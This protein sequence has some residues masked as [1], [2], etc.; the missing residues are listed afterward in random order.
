MDDDAPGDPGPGDPLVSDPLEDGSAEHPFDAIQEGID[1]SG[2]GDTVLVL[3]G[4]YTGFGNKNLDFGGRL[5]IVRSE[6]DPDSCIIN[7]QGNGRGFY[8]HSG[9]TAAAV[10]GGFTI[11]NG[12][13]DFN[14]G[15]V[16]MNDCSPTLINCTISASTAGSRGGGVHCAGDSSP[17]L[18]NCTITANTADS[19][20]GGVHCGGDSS[21]TLI[22]CTIAA[23]TSGDNGGGLY[24]F[25]TS[26][27][28]LANCILWGDTPDEVYC[29]SSCNPVVTYCDVQNGFGQTWFGAGCID[30]DPMFVDTDGPD[31]DPSTWED[32]DYRINL[33][34]PCTD[35]A[36]NTAVPPDTIDLDGDGDLDERIP[37]DGDGN[38]RF[39]DDPGTDDTGVPDPPAYPEVVDMGAYE[40]QEHDCNGNGVPDELD[41]SEGTSEDCT[42]NGIP[43]ECEPDCNENGVADSCDTIDGTSEDCNSNEI[44]DE[45]IDLESDCNDN[46]V[47][48]ECDIAEGTSEDC[49]G[50]GIPDECEPDC[51]DNGV[52]D[53][54]DIADGT[55]ED[56][57]E[58]G[59]PD[60]CEPDC[61]ENGVADSC[62]ITDGTSEDCTGNGIP[63]ECEPDCNE[64]GVPDLCEIYD[65]TSDDCNTNSIPDECD[66]ADGVSD[67]FDLNGVPDECEDCNGNGVP[68]ACDLDCAV[69]D[70]AAHPLG[71][72]TG[73][74]VDGDGILDNCE[75]GGAYF[76]NANTSAS[77]DLSAEAE[78]DEETDSDEI[79]VTFTDFYASGLNESRSVSA[80][81]GDGDARGTASAGVTISFSPTMITGSGGVNAYAV[82]EYCW[83]DARA[84]AELSFNVEFCAPYGG[85]W[86]FPSGVLMSDGNWPVPG[87]ASVRMTGPSGFNY[88]SGGGIWEY[89]TGHS[90]TLAPGVYVFTVGAGGW[91][92]PESGAEEEWGH[93]EFEFE[94]IPALPET[95]YV[96]PGAAGL[97]NGASWEHSF[98]GL[99][100]ALSFAM[101]NATVQEIRVAQ[102]T[103]VP[104]A[105]GLT[106]PRQATFQLVDGVALRG[107]YA[108]LA[109]PDDPDARDARLYETILGGDLNGDDGPSWENRADNT[110]HV[111]TGS[112]VDGAALLDGFVIRAGNADAP[113]GPDNLGGG[114]YVEG[115]SP[116][117]ANCRFTRN[118]AFGGGGAFFHGMGVPRLVNC[119]FDNNLSDDDGGAVGTIE[120]SSLGLTSCLF[121]ENFAADEGGGIFCAGNSGL[122][123]SN[124]TFSANIATN[125]GGGF[126]A[127]DGDASLA[128]CIFWSNSDSGG[129]DE[130]AQM[131]IIGSTHAVNYCCVQGWTGNLGGMQNIGSDP[132]FVDA[133]NDDYGLL[134]GSPCID[135]GCNWRLPPDATDLDGDGNADEIT[136]LDLDGEGRFFDDPDT[137]DNGCG[138]APIVDMGAYEFGG[139]GVLPCF[140]DLDNDL[141]VDLADLAALLDRY[142]NLDTCIGDLDCDGDVDLA[143]LAELLGVYGE[144][145]E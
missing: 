69:G 77:F 26:S 15:A 58:N 34:S 144:P 88:Y 56:C 85:T 49:T 62:D 53:S 33:G 74:D 107:G 129:T 40:C 16:R 137:S 126:Y 71:C 63:D 142:G 36:D 130:S 79:T 91:V 105:T 127:E 139:S 2:N 70:C 136:P 39:L 90:G 17:T 92:R 145:C 101:D 30:A 60:E 52:A 7:C 18:V 54:C 96:D 73:A 117:V 10:V 64:N 14:G 95:L 106:D 13:V 132:L 3:D 87:F 1:A 65:G 68:D 84:S 6:G 140:G 128:N 104:D 138:F 24:C 134:P 123:L 11:I 31:D 61:N 108:G 110:Y 133:T 121:F 9:E 25:S 4:T 22:G 83:G 76:S 109:N 124:C 143:D 119:I 122:T 86:E 20:G 78:C 35:A 89:L 32:N 37:F 59:I 48:D 82:M 21:P 38:P 23:N 97:N 120:S 118:V 66:I 42:G 43:D 19:R 131:H 135:A 27:P 116:V 5:I 29:D 111:V 93:F 113:S 102:G 100:G 72:G 112:G 99:S 98:K 45:C 44:P 75:C 67:D 28:S 81:A 8:F 51:N 80:R 12:N 50:N 114:M 41:I 115:G 47:P 55:S 46:S 57:S 103:Y 125:H 94:V 141:D